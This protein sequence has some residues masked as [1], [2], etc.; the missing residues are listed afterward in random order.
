MRKYLISTAVI[1]GCTLLA[2]CTSVSTAPASKLVASNPSTIAGL[3][4]FL[5]EGRIHAQ[6]VKGKDGSTP[7]TITITADI[8][9]D[10]NA[11]YFIKRDS[12][13]FYDDD[14]DLKTDSNGL[15]TAGNATSTDETVNI[16]GA[17]VALAKPLFLIPPKPKPVV[18]TTSPFDVTFYPK[19]VVSEDNP[20]SFESAESYLA[21]C[22]FA[23]EDSVTM[24][25]DPHPAPFK[26]PS[27]YAQALPSDFKDGIAFRLAVAYPVNIKSMSTITDINYTIAASRTVLI[28]DK[29]HTYYLDYSR[30]PFVAKKTN[31]SFTSGMLTEFSQTVPSPI[32]GILGIPKAII[33]AVVPIPGTSSSSTSSSSSAGKSTSSGGT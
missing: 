29:S 27:Q 33:Q 9:P 21:S 28:P 1:A 20:L 13:Y 31:L 18:T 6:G 11:A 17:V 15:L 16:I 4:Y 14:L 24:D 2:A 8:V 19:G 32:V 25:P 12:N 26:K 23:L 3:F 7:F 10:Y 30:V 22:G 5:P